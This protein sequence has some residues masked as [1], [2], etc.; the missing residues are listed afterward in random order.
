MIEEASGEVGSADSPGQQ[1]ATSTTPKELAEALD[2]VRASSPSLG[3][4]LDA[5][6]VTPGG[7]AD[8]HDRATTEEPDAEHPRS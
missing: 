5:A 1:E 4:A 7:L 2:A 6:E 8:A 3:A